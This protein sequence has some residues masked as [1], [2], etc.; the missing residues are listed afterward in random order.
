MASLRVVFW[1]LVRVWEGLIQKGQKLHVMSPFILNIFGLTTQPGPLF[2]GALAQA[3]PRP[4]P[5][6]PLGARVGFSQGKSRA[7][8]AKNGGRKAL[9]GTYGWSFLAGHF[10]SGKSFLTWIGFGRILMVFL[11][12]FGLNGQKWSKSVILVFFWSI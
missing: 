10:W 4:R 9:K 3:P 7:W 5:W 6:L 12:I 8:E 2:L 1:G 11:T